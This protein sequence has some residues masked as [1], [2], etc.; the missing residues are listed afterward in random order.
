MADTLARLRAR[1]AAARARIVLPET[2][3]ER[4]LAGAVAAARPGPLVKRGR[5]AVGRE[6]DRPLLDFVETLDGVDA[7]LFHLV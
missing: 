5:H 4:I 1:A 6:D 2:A 7:E 3:D